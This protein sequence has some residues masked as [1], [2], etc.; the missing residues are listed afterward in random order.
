MARQ[1]YPA[2]E[3]NYIVFKDSLNALRLGYKTNH[4]KRHG[5][6]VAVCSLQ[7]HKRKVWEK[8]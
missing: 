3:L 4:F 8:T 6:A 2:I 5:D 7:T 1:V